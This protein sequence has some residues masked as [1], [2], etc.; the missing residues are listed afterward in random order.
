[1]RWRSDASLVRWR[2]GMPSGRAVA[3]ARGEELGELVHR[4]P[5]SDQISGANQIDSLTAGEVEPV[6]KG[7]P[8]NEQSEMSGGVGRIQPCPT[9]G[10]ATPP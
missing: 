10:S 3:S 8:Q 4:W 2:A 7:S 9:R 1:M 5:R 6:E